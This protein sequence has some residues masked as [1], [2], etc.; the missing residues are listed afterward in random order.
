MTSDPEDF[1]GW[2][3]SDSVRSMIDDALRDADDGELYLQG[4]Q[5]ESLQFVDG[6]LKSSSFNTGEGFGLRTVCGEQVGYGH[7]NEFSE[8]ALAR[9]AEAA[10]IAKRG[11]SGTWDVSPERTNQKLYTDE[12]PIDLI[13]FEVKAKLLEDV[14]N[15]ARSKDPR[16]VQVSATI[17]AAWSKVEILRPGGERYRDTRPMVQFRVQIVMAE[18]DRQ[19]TGMSGGGRFSF[20]R[21]LDETV[22]QAEVD[23]A[24]RMAGVNLTSQPAPAGVMDVVLGPGWPGVMLH[25]AVGHGLEGDAIRKGTSAFSGLL[26]E[27]VAAK[28]VTVVDN[29]TISEVRGSLTTDDEGTPTGETVLIEDGILKAFM[30]DRQNARLM[31]GQSTGNGR[32]ESYAHL[33]MPRMTNTYM[34]NG[35]H[36][37]AEILASVEDGI[38]AV[39]FGGGQVDITSGNFV[40]SCTEAYRVRNGRQEEAIKGATLIGNGPEAMRRVTMIGNDLALD[41]GVGVCGKAGQSVPVCVGQPTLRMN[42]IT[43]GGTS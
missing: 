15:Y 34:E 10:S 41:P 14:N 39:N 4:A 19:E 28:G 25:E 12:N 18:G 20:E 23:E 3:E 31:G 22:W 33:P 27:Q 11:G 36:D 5:S 24:V 6:R 1:N 42:E 32:R 9:A 30:Q 7:S 16:V 8:A 13:P 26:G 38:Y 29:G 17:S 35:E 21:Y 37:P 43:I 2:P 40:F